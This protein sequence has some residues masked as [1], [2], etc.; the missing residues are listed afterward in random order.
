V[1]GTASRSNFHYSFWLLPA[2][3][4]R[5]IG[6]VYDFC[7][8]T[9]DIVDN[10]SP[11]EEKLADIAKWKSELHLAEKGLSEHPVLA[12]L[13]DT[14]RRFDIPFG[15]YFDLIRGVE[16]DLNTTRYET[17]EELAAYCALVASSVGLM[18]LGIFGRRNER[19]EEYARHL[20]LALQ[21]TNIIRDVATDA[22]LGR[23]YIPQ[24]DLL[25]FGCAGSDILAGRKPGRFGELMAFEASR[26]DGFYTAAESVLLPEDFTAMAPARVMAGIYQGT[27]RKI[28]RR[29]YDVFGGPIRLSGPMKLLIALRHGLAGAVRTR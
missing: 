22:G 29:G 10:D 14:S 27:L 26:A 8:A 11:P 18:C 12:P 25:R 9:D 15:H 5:A 4:R 19:T 23:I 13:A 21:L 3:R 24:D 1:N 7:R 28:G 2:D 17:F 16:M 20:G 6:V